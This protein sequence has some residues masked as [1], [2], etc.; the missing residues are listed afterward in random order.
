MIAANH[1]EWALFFRVVGLVLKTGY[2]RSWCLCRGP[3]GVLSVEL[4]FQLTA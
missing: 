2:N 1:S 4:G 3:V